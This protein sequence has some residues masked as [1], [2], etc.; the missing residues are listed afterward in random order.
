MFQLQ[1]EEGRCLDR[2]H[3]GHPV[4]VPTPADQ[5]QRWPQFSP[6]AQ[7][8][9][10]ALVH[11]AP[12]RLRDPSSAPSACSGTAPARST[13][14]TRHSPQALMHVASVAIVNEKSDADRD[15]INDQPQHALNSRIVLEQAKARSPTSASWT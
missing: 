14:T 7:T 6:A 1:R 4:T 15:V 5:V 3:T 13:P 9:G 11:A 2:N 10:F 12:M 8:L